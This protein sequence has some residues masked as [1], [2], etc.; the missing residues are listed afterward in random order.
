MP[1][2][3]P[4]ELQLRSDELARLTGGSEPLGSEG[5]S[6]GSLRL[7]IM[8]AVRVAWPRSGGGLQP[9][10]RAQLGVFWRFLITPG[11]SFCF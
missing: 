1:P 8:A 2:P 6:L 5:L 3:R 9:G 4:E 7:I 10:F 11:E